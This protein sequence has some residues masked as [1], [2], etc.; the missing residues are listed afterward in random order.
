MYKKM[1][2]VCDYVKKSVGKGAF[3]KK[4][5]HLRKNNAY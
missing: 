2:I 5:Y 4:K 3:F 1:N